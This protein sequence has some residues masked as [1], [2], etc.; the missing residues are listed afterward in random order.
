MKFAGCALVCVSSSLIGLS[1]KFRTRK[2]VDSLKNMLHC[3]RVFENEIR[4]AGCDIF[5]ATEKMLKLAN[6]DNSKVFNTFLE[7]A[8]SSDGLALS[9]VW[10][11]AI[12]K[13]DNCVFY[14]KEDLKCFKEF[15]AILG[16][17]DVDTQLKNIDA[18]NLSINENIN[19]IK[20]KVCKSD[21]IYSKL[22]IYIGIIIAVLLI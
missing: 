8:S 4:Y 16:S 19:L 11:S 5:C 13:I 3:M 20:N 22:G 12:S 17:G 21:E 15:G 2:R 18:F 1:F 10:Q 7:C 6:C 14:E 9:E